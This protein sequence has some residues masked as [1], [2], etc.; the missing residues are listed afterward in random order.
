M[1][2]KRVVEAFLRLDQKLKSRKITLLEVFD[3]Y[4]VNKDGDISLDEF[5]RIMKRLDSSMG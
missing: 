5:K 2:E 4:D 1:I 3:A